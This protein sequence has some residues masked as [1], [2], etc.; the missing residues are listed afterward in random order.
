MEIGYEVRCV[1]PCAFDLQYCSILGYGVKKLFDE[2]VS[3]A[4][5]TADPKGEVSPLYLKDV[6]DENG[7]VKPRLVNMKGEKAKLIFNNC[8][9]YITPQD[10]EGAKKFV[11]NPED[12]DFR[13]ILNW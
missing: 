5:V 4:M 6:E 13:K 9:Q 3:G 7:K 10:Y 2:G 8:L 1:D 12:Y 11:E